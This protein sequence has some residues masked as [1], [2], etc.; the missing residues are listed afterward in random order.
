MQLFKP[1]F[2]GQTAVEQRSIQSTNGYALCFGQHSLDTEAHIGYKKGRKSRWQRRRQ[3]FRRSWSI[4]LSRHI[5]SSYFL[6]YA[7]S[8]CNLTKKKDRQRL[9]K[10]KESHDGFFPE[11]K[12]IK[13]AKFRLTFLSICHNLFPKCLL[14]SIFILRVYHDHSTSKE[15]VLYFCVLSA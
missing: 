14:T 12:I 6:H 11:M 1:Y 8:R 2:C 10:Q 4:F 5:S 3:D 13:W 15:H 9:K 7:S